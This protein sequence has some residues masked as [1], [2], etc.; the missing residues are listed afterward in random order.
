MSL[1][2][3]AT[4]LTA[5]AFSNAAPHP[6]DVTSITGH[7]VVGQVTSW[8]TQDGPFTVEH[9]AG[10]GP[11]G[12][13]LVFFWS[14]EADWQV[15]N[16]SRI[17]GQRIASTV[18]SWQTQDGPFTVEH[19]AAHSLSGELLVFFWSPQADWQVVNVSRITGRRIAGTVTSWQTQDGPFTVEHLAGRSPSGELLVFFWS[20]QADWQVVNVS[21][22]TGRRIA[23]T[24][25]SWQTQD[26]PFT[27]EH[28]AG[29]NPSGELLVFFWSP[30]ADWQVVNVSRI[31]GQ[32]IASDLTSWQTQDGDVNVEH[33]AGVSPMGELLTFYWTP[34]TDWR[35]VNITRIAGGGRVAGAPTVYQLADGDENVE[36][37]G[38]RSSS[39][40]LLLYWWKPS[41]DW[42]A[43]NLSDLTGFTI[44]APPQGWVT[45]DGD[46]TVEHFAA[47]DTNGHLLVF[48]NYTP[49][50]LLTDQLSEPFQSLQR[51]RVPRRMIS[52][53]WD[54]HD[55]SS[56]ASTR[57]EVEAALFG[58]TD[59]VRDYFLENSRNYFTIEN[60]AVLGW[61]DA[62]KPFTYYACP[63]QGFADDEYFR[64]LGCPPEGF[65]RDTG[66]VTGHVEK[67]TEAIRKAAMDFDFAAFDFN[68]DGVLGVDE[69]GIAIVIPSNDPF[70]TVRQPF[71][72]EE[73]LEALVVDGVRVDVITEFYIGTP[74]N[75]GR[76]LVAHELSHL[77][78]GAPDMYFG[79]N[80]PSAAGDFSLMDRTYKTTHLD[81]FH[82]LKLGWVR[83]KIISRTGQYSL[84]NVETHHDVW[85]LL[86]PAHG[87]KEYFI[88]ENRWRGDSYDREMADDGG[89]AVWHIIED[90]AVYGTVPPPRSVDQADWDGVSPD[91]WGRRTIRMI[92]PVPTSSDD[93]H[94]LWDGAQPGTD[95]DLLSEGA[96]PSHAELRWADG[97]PSGFNVRSISAAGPEMQAIIDVPDR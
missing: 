31:T 48:F 39:G 67:W 14:P 69:L 12:E 93:S 54:W 80:N 50:R 13:L 71:G 28:L 86:D 15:V 57:G 38:V 88:I 5:K 29:R 47:P 16:V 19:L 77:F 1:L 65:M 97:T 70:G 87:D 43:V 94:A 21:R 26:G 76:G 46:S 17:T 59:S 84:G 18:T 82:K 7:R 53:L 33:L 36:V 60:A 10:R 95:Y 81:P 2:L 41:R 92:R 34:Q 83:P 73:P 45:P 24:V 75:R 68:G 62:D 63:S 61:Y 40:A 6:I 42:Q 37:L 91:D 27:V 90:P 89:L 44:S 64:S 51:A 30:Q 78:L 66:W 79:F 4:P 11:S 3:V 56:P 72:R 25:T 55:P 96:D 58:A 74:P 85:I 22:I 52:I 8:Q 32:R 9:L 20:P 23:G 49:A 35:V